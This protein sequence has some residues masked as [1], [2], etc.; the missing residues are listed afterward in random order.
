MNTYEERMAVR[1]AAQLA[2][3]QRSHDNQAEPEMSADELNLADWGEHLTTLANDALELI[4]RAER[5]AAAGQTEAAR[6][7]LECAARQ[8]GDVA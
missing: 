1:I 5:A 4:G 2:S 8:L 7:M 6:D 3:A